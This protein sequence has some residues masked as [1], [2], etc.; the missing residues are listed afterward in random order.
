MAVKKIMCACGSGIG[1]SLIVRMNTEKV[2][3]SIGRDDIEVFHSTTSDARKGAAD[4]FI[5]GRDLADFVSGLDHVIT[6]DNL[7]SKDELKQ[8]LEAVFDEM[9]ESYTK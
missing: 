3:K 6:L 4:I 2:L 7:V 9:G 5:V 1:S 8:K